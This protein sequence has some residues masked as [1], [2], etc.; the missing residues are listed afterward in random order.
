MMK[1]KFCFVN[2]KLNLV[3]IN[4]Y[5]ILYLSIS[6]IKYINCQTND[7]ESKII[8]DDKFKRLEETDL[9]DPYGY[10]SCQENPS[11]S[12]K[13]CFNNIL[14]FAQKK[15]E[16]N[17]FAMN[18]NGDFLV[19][20]N[21][22]INYDEYTS[23]RLF[24]GLTKNGSYFFSNESSFK[25]EF[26]INIDEEILDGNEFFNLLGN[27]N[28]KNLF[29]STKNDINNKDQYLFSINTEKS[30]V[31]L[32]DLNNINNNYFV[33]SF[34]KFFNLNEDDYYFIFDY[35]LFEL[36]EKSEY[37][38][39]FIPFYNVDA[40]ILN[41]NFMKKFRFKSFDKDTYEELCS[42]N[43]EEFLD[44]K[45]INIFILEDSKALGV[46]TINES[47]I[48]EE[49]QD[50]DGNFYDEPNYKFN[51]KF[52]NL[53]LKSLSFSKEVQLINDLAYSNM[54][55]NLFVKSLYLNILDKSIIILIYINDYYFFEYDLFEIKL[56]DYQK[57]NNIIFPIENGYLERN[58]YDF[59]ARESL[60]DFIKINDMRVSFIY[61]PSS[62]S[63]QLNIILIDINQYDGFISSNFFSIDLYNY[64]PI[65]IKGFAYNGFLL[66]A[67]SGKLEN[68]Y[69]YFNEDFSNYLSIFMAFG[70]ANGTDS[71]IDISK[72][73]FKDKYDNSNN[74]FAFLF[75]NLTLENNIFGYLPYGIIKLISTPKEISIYQRNLSTGE[76]IPLEESYIN[77]GCAGNDYYDFTENCPDYD[78]IIK[79]NKTLIKTSQYYYI[80]YQYILVELGPLYEE[81]E[82]ENE[83]QEP[84]DSQQGDRRI[85]REEKRNLNYFYENSFPSG[86]I[87]RLK[88]KLCHEYCE[89]CYELGTSNDDQKCSS[90]LP[91]YQ[92]DYLYFLNRTDENPDNICVPENYYYNKYRIENRL[93]K[94][95]ERSRN[96][97]NTTNNKRICFP[98]NE[99]YPC[100]STYPIYNKTTREC[101]YCDF[102]R[103]KNGE[104]T[105]EDLTMDSC[106]QCDYEC[107]IIGGCNFN[108]F[109]TTNNDFY[110][111]IING[112][113]IYNYDCGVALKLSNSNGYSAQVT[114]IKNELN[115]LKENENHNFSIIDFKDCAYLLRNQNKLDSNSNLV[116]L[117]Y[118]NDNQ[119]S[120]GN[121]KSIQYE[122]YL[123]NSNTKLDL[124]A[125]KN[126]S[127]NI[128]V[129]IE[130]N[131]ET[132]K[133]YN[134]MKEQGYN[135]F[136]KNN[137]FYH[138][139]CTPYKSVDG[140]DVILF[141]RLNDIYE[142]NKLECQDN[143][144][145][146]EYLPESKYLKCEC[147]ITNEER[148]NTKEPEKITGK[149][150]SKSFHNVLHNS[151]Y[152]V[153]RCYNLVFRK[154]TIKENVGSILSNIY[155][156]GYLI[157]FGIFC[158][159]K[160]SYLKNEIDKLFKEENNDKI[161]IEIYKN[162][163]SIY[164]KNTIKEKGNND[165]MKD[166][167]IIK[168][169]KNKKINNK[170]KEQ[171]N[172]KINEEMDNENKEE[173]NQENKEEIFDENKDEISE[174]NK[175]EI[176]QENKE[177]IFDENKEEIFEE[178][179]EEKID[180]NKEEK[181]DENSEE[182][183]EEN[184]KK[185]DEE[186]LK[187]INE[188]KKGDDSTKINIIKKES[189]SNLIKKPKQKIGI[190][191]TEYKKYFNNFVLGEN[192][193]A[194]LEKYKNKNKIKK[195]KYDL[196]ENKHLAS[197]DV[198]TNKLFISDNEPMNFMGKVLNEKKSKSKSKKNKKGK[199][200][201]KIK[202]EE[203][204]FKIINKDEKLFKKIEKEENDLQIKEI[205]SNNSNQNEKEL[206]N[207]KINDNEEKE[208]KKSEKELNESN[209]SEKRDYESKINLR[210]ENEFKMS[211]REINISKTSEKEENISKT[212]EKDENIS[213]II[214]KEDNISRI[215]E[216]VSKFSQNESK[217]S[218][219]ESKL[220]E[221]EEKSTTRKDEEKINSSEISERENN[222]K[223]SLTDYEL[224]NLEYNDALEIDN[225]DFFMTY[226]YLLK[227]ENII[228]FTFFNWN[229]FNLFSIKLSKLFLAICSDMA[230]N[231]F[232]FSDESM[233][234]IYASGGEH[235][236]T[237]QFAQMVYSTMISQILQIFINYLTMTDIHYYQLKQLKKDNKIS[238]KET[239]F[240]LKCIKYKLI[241]Y[242]SSTFLLFLF[243]WYTSSAFCAVYPNTQGILVA[244]SYTSFFMG[245]IYPF[246]LYLVP[247]ALRI[248]SL[249]SKR[250]KNYKI[251][252]SLSKIIPFF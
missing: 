23:S 162:N 65:K 122:V 173:I 30:I 152:K 137:K 247:T 86:R 131:E 191:Y 129:P 59:N 58:I 206:N 214:V 182:M 9:D 4:F 158:Y 61:V 220:S 146:A 47:V 10:I 119:V 77:S 50:G 167:E 199:K 252:Y 136:D 230:F 166:I 243:F 28:S 84:E 68:A 49:S 27:Q 107:F 176:N 110:E 229:D 181:D 73:L 178:N 100:P 138:D 192:Y 246:A 103:F 193:V 213:R 33:W 98:N 223:E 46:L 157:A 169:V 127:I 39:A 197:K 112:G 201:K 250:N 15:Y 51:L 239:S 170:I 101:F 244:D 222:G 227:R 132:Q 183:D 141:D 216:I 163:I 88:F 43:Y 124:S 104:C 126:T 221:K 148:I 219:Y 249:K 234:N 67:A 159:T 37:I 63:Q 78:Y 171:M 106:T 139:I 245:L 251:L 108:N 74:F 203:K 45:I 87:N 3:K 228:L 118:E 76:E 41:V 128:Y 22:H 96:Y 21:E 44:N 198:L 225:R 40:D 233:H 177:E 20:Y 212:S 209:T 235:G 121:E 188:E 5:I 208:L 12:N 155:F 140:T 161:T 174:E 95:N 60:N 156:I 117:K 145:Y 36:K 186:I 147:N 218:E 55:E 11:I 204:L 150:V 143:C 102:K 194:K 80:D 92:Y 85:R 16:V 31:E 142:K 38:I 151:N 19:Q 134:S 2:N 226:W 190:K 149:S 187:E 210:E 7:S 17:N 48:I 200:S 81:E 26:N 196:S 114:T 242:F 202:K 93:S 72:F 144:E 34:S 24:Y 83:N 71:I 238:S 241:A 154:V 237:E 53:N 116:I 105:A 82:E 115:S 195:L 184:I 79:Q 90:C 179:K 133:L 113:Y 35:E 54:N 211:E 120:N 130:L 13:K 160:A 57:R 14:I 75:K 224:N 32:Y 153:L 70:Y 99:E 8:V 18:K 135:I 69:N 180:D 89:T 52:Y 94:C 164:R 111:R 168:I 236:W 62:L 29:I 217:L 207:I 125:C 56:I 232:F 231:V 123:P 248:I 189:S 165:D 91:E 175:E 172:N 1:Y 240:I 185:L 64:S 25:H 97:F 205:V 6:I 109:N 42:I 215:S 66:F